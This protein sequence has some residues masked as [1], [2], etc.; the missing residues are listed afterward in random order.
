[1]SSFLRSSGEIDCYPPGYCQ[2]S[3]WAWE[4][5]DSN[6][7]PLLLCRV[8][9]HWAT[10]CCVS[11]TVRRRDDTRL[12]KLLP[13]WRMPSYLHVL[14]WKSVW[15]MKNAWPMQ[16]CVSYGILYDLWKYAWS[17]K[18]AW[19]LRVFMTS[20]NLPDP[21]KFSFLLWK[22]ACYVKV[23]KPYGSLHDLWKFIYSVSIKVCLACEC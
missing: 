10:S 9:S 19:P 20:D 12:N 11:L 13:T 5:P 4:V 14:F 21:W 3:P 18:F 22:C 7:G 23:C 1:M 16:F 6:Q 2:G 8:Y 17:T 15:H